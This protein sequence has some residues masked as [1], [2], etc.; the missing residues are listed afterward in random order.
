MSKLDDLLSDLANFD[1]QHDLQG[2]RRTREAIVTEHPDSEE[3][4]EASY[5]IGLDCLFRERDLVTAVERFEEAAKRKHAFW[6]AAA[7]TSL[8]LCFHHQGRTQKALLELR[9]VAYP[10]TPSSHSVTALGFIESILDQSGNT[11]DARRARKD[12][13]KQLEQLLETARVN[14]RGSDRGFYLHQLALALREQGEGGRAKEL[15]NEA[16][17][18]GPEVLGADLFR[19]VA[20]ALG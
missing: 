14:G 5:K 10:E 4:V 8:G 12:R 6:S 20:S 13:V 3:A 17:D 18:L 1:A 2:L 19:A 11:E 16:K 7:R 15:L 9:K